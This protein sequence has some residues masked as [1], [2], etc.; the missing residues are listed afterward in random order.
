VRREIEKLGG[1]IRVGSAPGRGTTFTITLPLTL[2]ITRALL[3]RHGGQI[4]AVPLAFAERLLDLTEVPVVESAG[5][6]RVKLED[7]H[8]PL[9]TLDAVLGRPNGAGGESGPGFA[10][11]LRAGEKRL[12]VAVDRFL[13]QEE[14]VVKSLGDLLTGHPLLT[15]VT[16]S[17]DGELILILDVPGLLDPRAGAASGAGPEARLAGPARV[18]FV[19]D[20]L[21]VRKVAEKLLT[22]LGAEVALAVDGQEALE[23]LGRQSFDVVFTDLEMPRLHGY[24]LIQTIAASPALSHLPVVVVTSRSGQKHRD[25]AHAL[26]ARDYL[27]KPFN[28][29]VLAQMLRKWAPQRG[30]A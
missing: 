10:V 30:R 18:L 29:E 7:G 12:A 6:R 15:G 11:L 16:L 9:S 26:G 20:S 4:F 23:I 1:D 21:S 14:I 25:E 19:D 5:V 17:G 28:R 3:L 27:T 24:E 8:Q 22:E 13:G 2:A